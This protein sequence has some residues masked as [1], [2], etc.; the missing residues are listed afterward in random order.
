MKHKIIAFSIL[1]GNLAEFTFRSDRSAEFQYTLFI[2][3]SVNQYR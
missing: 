2:F 3:D 1:T